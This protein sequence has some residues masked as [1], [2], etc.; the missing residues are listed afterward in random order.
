MN[1]V[2]ALGVGLALFNILLW[3]A[4][5]AIRTAADAAFGRVIERNNPMII[6]GVQELLVYFDPWLARFVFPVVYTIGLAA[7]AFLGSSGAGAGQS[8]PIAVALL[9]LG[10]EAVWLFLIA[11]AVCLRGPNWNL[12][13]PGEAWDPHKVVPLNYINLSDY[14]WNAWMGRPLEGMHWS[15]RELPGIGLLAGYFLAGVGLAI[16]VCWPIR[17]WPTYGRCLALVLLVQ[18]AAMVP[19][20]MLLRWTFDL[21]YVIFI[22]EYFLNV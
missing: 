22:P 1:R 7:I 6:N 8:R 20:K 13:W 16:F 5:P 9:L 11:V 19:L 14:Y 21:K 2:K 12:F 10:F 15:L 4:V 18:L 3:F 17:R